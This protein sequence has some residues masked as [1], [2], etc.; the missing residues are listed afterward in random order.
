MDSGEK[1]TDK[2][3]LARGLKILAIALIMIVLST[4]LITFAF[5]NK[6]VLPLYIVLPLAI[7]AMAGTIYLIFKGIRTILKS[8]F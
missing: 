4:Y 3:L 1:H 8:I 5:L 2:K 7:I 6:D